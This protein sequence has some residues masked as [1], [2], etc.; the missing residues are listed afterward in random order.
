MLH[1]ASYVVLFAALLFTGVANAASDPFVGEWKL[2]PSKSTFV[3][4]MKVENVGGNKYVFDL[5]GGPEPIAVDGTEQP[6]VGN[7]TL[8][9]TAGGA[10]SWTVVRKKAGRMLLMANWTLSKD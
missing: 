2:D 7:T 8:S 4:V 6:G 5:G 1:R 9:I 10:G 3:D